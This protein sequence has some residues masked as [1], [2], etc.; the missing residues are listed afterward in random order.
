[1][2]S[3]QVQIV[4]TSYTCCIT[5]I[6]EIKSVS[7]SFTHSF[8]H[9]HIHSFIHSFSQ[10][11][12]QSLIHP[13][14]HSHIHTFIHSF[15]QSFFHSF[16]HSFIHTFIYSFTLEVLFSNLKTHVFTCYRCEKS[17]RESLKSHQ[18]ITQRDNI[19]ARTHDMSVDP[20]E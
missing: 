16:I 18:F 4:T 11:V 7:Q 9:S 10:S 20:R 3:S 12:S 17:A 15:I 13:F 8:I 5:S 2:S 6:R 14:I 1:M 19:R